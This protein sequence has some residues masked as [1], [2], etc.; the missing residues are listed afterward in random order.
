M[1]YK[2]PTFW[3]VLA[4]VAV[5][6]IVAVC[7]LTNP[8]QGTTTT[9]LLTNETGKSENGVDAGNVASADEVNAQQETDAALQEALDK[10][11]RTGRGGE[12]SKCGRA[13]E[14]GSGESCRLDPNA[15]W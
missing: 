5:C 11:E 2:K 7:F 12:G 10:S 8:K 3:V 13:G 15:E 9:I 1:N 6:V 4:A 14:T